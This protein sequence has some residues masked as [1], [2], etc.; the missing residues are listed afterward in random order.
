M[1]PHWVSWLIDF[2]AG[3]L[4]YLWGYAQGKKDQ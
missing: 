3:V 4:L 1:T 2:S